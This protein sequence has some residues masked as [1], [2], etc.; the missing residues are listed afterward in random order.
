MKTYDGF[1]AAMDRAKHFLVLY[2]IL[3]DTRR[4]AVR[5]DWAVPFKK[6]M[7][8]P[9]ADQ[10]VRIDGKR[11]NSILILREA[12]GIDRDRFTHE[13]L[14]ELLR[15]AVVAAVSALDRYL[16][17][18]V[19]ERSWKLLS[20]S[21]AKVPRELSEVAIPVVRAKAALDRL[22]GEPKG[23][24]GHLIKQAIQDVLHREC[25]F[26]KPD[27]VKR[28]ADMLGLKNFWSSVASSM[29][30]KLTK[31]Q[32]IDQLRQIAARRNQI[33]HEADLLR[34]VKAKRLTLREIKR[35]ET[36]R[37]V[38]WL[39]TFVNAIRNVAGQRTI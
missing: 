13:Y 10:I 37:I 23:R 12:L 38:D 28:A 6:M 34:R 16:H 19:V 22:R 32:V 5:S 30:G 14:S 7:H 9:D 3:R 1:A 27:D 20:Q 24:P 25:T 26:Q 8:W 15:A 33:V 18:L 35:A 31:Q 36:E 21:E 4:R 17:D 39:E 11:K 2:D 29:P